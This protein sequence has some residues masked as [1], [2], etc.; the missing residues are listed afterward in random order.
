MLGWRD[1]AEPGSYDWGRADQF[2]GR[3]AAH[4]IRSVPF[5]WG[6]PVGGQRGLAQ[7]PI[8][9]AAES[10]RG[11]TSSRRRWRAMDR[12]AATGPPTTPAVPG[13]RAAADPV[14]ADLE[15]AQPEEVLQPGQNDQQSAQKYA[16]L[17]QISHDAIKT[18]DPQ[19]R[20]V[21][22]GM[23]AIGDSKAWVFLDSLQ[24]AGIEGDF[25]A[26]ALH[27]YSCEL[28]RVAR[29]YSE[30]R[31]SMTNRADGATPLWV[32]EFAW[33]SGPPDRS[34]RNKGLT[35]QQQLLSSSFKMFLQPPHDWNLQRVYWFLW[36]DPPLVPGARPVQLLRHRGAFALRP[37][38][39]AAYDAF[40]GFTAETTPPV[41][42]ITSGPR[43]RP[44]QGLDPHL[45]LCLKQGRLHL[46]AA[47]MPRFS[48]APRPSL[49]L[50]AHERRPYL[51]VKAIDAPGNESATG[52]GPSPSTPSAPDAPDHPPPSRRRRPTTTAPR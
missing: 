32:T 12:G 15:R 19:A 23:P 25:D 48:P 9:S 7:P 8:G 34:C 3:L 46:P 47:T 4:G 18:R 39:E 17:L 10:R 16:T 1:G 22:A 36:R 40:R 38:P 45:L 49:G 6:S 29:R 24:G 5:V 33:G 43:G 41:A 50:A 21:L 35:G 13:R 37:D 11:G 44:H 28:D 27:P 52:R 42:S 31:A 51:F 2:I 20:I 26:A 14:L 30:F